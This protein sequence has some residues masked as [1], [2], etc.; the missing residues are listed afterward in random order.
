MLPRRSLATVTSRC[1]AGRSLNR[2]LAAARLESIFLES[3]LA[4]MIA[5]IAGDTF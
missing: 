3:C 2:L 5:L 1:R 4:Q